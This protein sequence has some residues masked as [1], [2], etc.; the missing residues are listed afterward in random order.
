MI[1][2]VRRAAE[3]LG[4]FTEDDLRAETGLGRDQVAAAL[5]VLQGSG[6]ILPATYTGSA[7]D[8]DPAL[9]SP[10]GGAHCSGCP[11]ATVCHTGTCPDF[12]DEWKRSPRYRCASAG[13]MIRTEVM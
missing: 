2:E 10:A 3:R 5:T 4:V 12:A 11:I 7:P 1:S 13:S 6:R 8:A 9:S